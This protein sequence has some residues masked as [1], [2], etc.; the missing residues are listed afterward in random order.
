MSEEY[1]ERCKKFEKTVAEINGLLCNI[2]PHKDDKHMMNCYECCPMDRIR[3][4]WEEIN[5]S[6][7][8]ESVRSSTCVPDEK[9]V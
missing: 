8:S 4:N 6:K 9:K 3:S 5:E 1:F 7:R 2:C